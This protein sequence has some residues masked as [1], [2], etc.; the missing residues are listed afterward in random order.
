VLLVSIAAVALSAG[1]EGLSVGERAARYQGE[2]VGPLSKHELELLRELVLAAGEPVARTQLLTRCWGGG[3]GRTQKVDVALSRLRE[4][5][6]HTPFTVHAIR[7]VGYRLWKTDGTRRPASLAAAAQGSFLLAEDDA[8]VRRVLTRVVTRVAPTQAVA[9]LRQAADVARSGTWLGAILDI[10]LPD[11]SG[12]DLIPILRRRSPTIP[13][14]VISGR[15]DHDTI[16][17]VAMLAARYSMKPVDSRVLEVFVEEALVG[18]RPPT[19]HLEAEG[20]R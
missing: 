5:L 17:R 9:T 18:P 13:I 2:L 12:L 15:N 8:L 11:G 20:G 3:D 7:G 14:L 16:N 6:A 19:L 4:K 10:G 1:F